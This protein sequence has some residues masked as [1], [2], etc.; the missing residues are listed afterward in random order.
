MFM[1]M[2]SSKMIFRNFSNHADLKL[3]KIS[4]DNLNQ[5][6][7]SNLHDSELRVG[8]EGAGG[9]GTSKAVSL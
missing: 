3:I 4:K 8:G 9:V 5:K 7:V 6:H 1:L 2:L